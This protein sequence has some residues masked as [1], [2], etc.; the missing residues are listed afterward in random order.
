MMVI[1][2]FADYSQRLLFTDVL[3]VSTYR[4]TVSIQLLYVTYTTV[5]CQLVS[6]NS[7]FDTV[8][9]WSNKRTAS[10]WL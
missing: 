5:T 10:D 1:I 3:L 2:S 9:I 6:L 7:L 8:R 4:Y